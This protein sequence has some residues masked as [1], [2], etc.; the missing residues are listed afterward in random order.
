MPMLIAP[1]LWV[2][3][4]RALIAA[5]AAAAVNIVNDLMEE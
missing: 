5:A 1:L 3:F 4:E 2:V